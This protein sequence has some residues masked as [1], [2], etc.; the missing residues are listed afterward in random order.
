MHS[1]LEVS[2]DELIQLENFTSKWIV[3]A[4]RSQ[5]KEKRNLTVMKIG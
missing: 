1:H 4:T 5:P 2:L 3:S